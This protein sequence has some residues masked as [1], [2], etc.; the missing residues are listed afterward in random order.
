[1][2]VFLSYVFRF[3][4]GIVRVF[5]SIVSLYLL[6]FAC[7]FCSFGVF[8]W[9]VF[10]VADLPYLNK[11]DEEVLKRLKVGDLR[12]DINNE[13]CPVEISELIQKCMTESPRERPQFSEL[14]IYIG[15][16]ITGV[17]PGNQSS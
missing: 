6:R 4:F 10:H 13:L 1:V 5:R 7:L 15:D 9:E 12:L 11:S 2:R 14:C 16:I 17:Q 8:V 3:T